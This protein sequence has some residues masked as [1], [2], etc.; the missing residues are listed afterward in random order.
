[1][2]PNLGDTRSEFDYIVLFFPQNEVSGYSNVVRLHVKVRDM[3]N[4]GPQFLGVN[5]LE[6]YDASV[7]GNT[8]A[9]DFVF[10]VVAIDLDATSPNNKVMY[11]FQASCPDCGGFIINP[12]NGLIFA[13]QRFNPNVKDIYRLYVE[14]Y[15]G[16]PGISPPDPNTG[17]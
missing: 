4:Q 3:N 13:D 11:R 15:D 10:A 14:A 12:H 2:H 8:K 5:E 7:T 16:A 6:Q 1:M 9:G 17:T